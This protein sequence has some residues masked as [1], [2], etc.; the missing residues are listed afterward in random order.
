MAGPE[1]SPET[2]DFETDPERIER[3]REFLS[4]RIPGF[5]GPELYTK[6]CLY[7]TT[8]DHKLIIDEVPGHPQILVALGA[9]EGFKFASLM[10]RILSELALEG[11]THFPIESFAATR[12]ELAGEPS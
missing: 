10:G 9:G 8:P 3:Y 7:C 2:R 12:S 5:V 1:V 6:T 4:N 11:A